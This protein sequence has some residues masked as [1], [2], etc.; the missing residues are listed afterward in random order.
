MQRLK[1]SINNPARDCLKEKNPYNFN[2]PR[3]S[4]PF[5]IRLLGEL[6]DRT[7]ESQEVCEFKYLNVPPWLIPDINMRQK[8]NRIKI[9]CWHKLTFL[10]EIMRCV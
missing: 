7:I 2:K 10:N 4:K 8:S 3:A 9:I 5:Q 1:S 6:E